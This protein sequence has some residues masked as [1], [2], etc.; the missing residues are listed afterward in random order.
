MSDPHRF[1]TLRDRA[2]KMN[3][4]LSWVA[5]NTN[6]G[7]GFYVL[8]DPARGVRH[9]RS[10]LDDMAIEVVALERADRGLRQALGP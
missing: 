3:C 4:T 9:G 2:Q 8:H 6:G 1:A 10:E 5:R 7:G